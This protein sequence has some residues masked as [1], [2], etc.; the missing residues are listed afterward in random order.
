MGNR[1][2]TNQT[3]GKLGLDRCASVD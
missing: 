3:V 2:N 1:A